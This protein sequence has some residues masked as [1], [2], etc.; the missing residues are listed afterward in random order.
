MNLVVDCSF[1]MSSILPD[2]T[3]EKIEDVFYRISQREFTVYVPS[4][5]Y[6]ECTNVL[7]S[8]LNRKRITQDSFEEY[9]NLLRLMPITVDGFSSTPEAIYSIGKLANKHNLS[10]YDASYLDLAI[11]LEASIASLDK[12]LLDS[13][14]R[15]NINSVL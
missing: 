7:V 12:K 2:E 3:E 11:R 10:A 4:I 14:L 8:S 6:L 5:F 9:T 1:F 15:A 13:C